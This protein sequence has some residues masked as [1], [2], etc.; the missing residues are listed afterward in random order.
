[1]IQKAALTNLTK[2]M[3]LLRFNEARLRLGA[4]VEMF[5][6]DDGLWT[7]TI[8]WDDMQEVNFHDLEAFDETAVTA[9]NAVPIHAVAALSGGIDSLGQLSRKFESNGRPGAIGFDTKGGF[10]YGAYQI[11]TRTGAMANFLA[12]LEKQ[13]PD[14]SLKLGAA[15]GTLAAL[16]GSDAFKNAWFKLAMDS[17]FADAQHKYIASTHYEPFAERLLDSL[18]LDLDARTAVLRDVAW[19]V[20]VQH[21]PA[22]KVFNAAL[23]NKDVGML[24]DGKIIPLVYGERSNVDKYFPSSTVQVKAALVARFKEELKLAM[25]R[26]PS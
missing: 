7:V 5:E 10:S 25:S 8:V 19:S 16:A 18:G 12:F 3:A 6:Q 23:L 24:A 11:A 26:L 15:G 9:P 1:M 21:G 4:V 17:A 22:N 14:F 20:A 13:Y 2:P